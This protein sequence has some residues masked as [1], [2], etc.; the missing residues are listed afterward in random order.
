MKYLEKVADWKT[1][2]AYLLQDDDGSKSE[3][4]ERENQF[5]VAECR[6]AMIREYL[7]S[8]NVSWESLLRALKRADY[9]NLAEEIKLAE[10]L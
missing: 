1:L 4:I 7:Q 6:A 10:K 5:M 3:A 2:A 9:V 8:C